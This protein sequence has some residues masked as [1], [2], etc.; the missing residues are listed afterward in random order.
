[1]CKS[2]LGQDMHYYHGIS[3]FLLQGKHSDRRERSHL[4]ILDSNSAHVHSLRLLL[5]LIYFYEL[6]EVLN[7][8]F[9]HSQDTNCCR[10]CEGSSVS[11]LCPCTDIWPVCP[12]TLLLRTLGVQVPLSLRRRMDSLVITPNMMDC[13]LYTLTDTVF[14]TTSHF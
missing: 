4:S 3:C 9:Y 2:A 8:A 1:M 10:S 11:S 14:V 12:V 7:C 6:R 13:S 5:L